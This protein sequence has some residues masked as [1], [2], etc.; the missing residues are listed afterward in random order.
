M[1][2]TKSVIIGSS[3]TKM[4]HTWKMS[5]PLKR[6]EVATLQPIK[7]WAWVITLR[8]QW[9]QNSNVLMQMLR[10]C[11]T[12]VLVISRIFR[13]PE[14]GASILLDILIL[15]FGISYLIGPSVYC[16]LQTY[17]FM[18]RV[19][20]VE[21]WVRMFHGIWNEV[22][23]WLCYSLSFLVLLSL[24]VV[25]V[26]L[27]FITPYLALFWISHDR[28]PSHRFVCNHRF[29][30]FG[31]MPAFDE[32]LMILSEYHLFAH[33]TAYFSTLLMWMVA[34]LH[35]IWMLE[36]YLE[37]PSSWLMAHASVWPP[38]GLILHMV[39][40][41]CTLMA[42]VLV[43]GMLLLH[44]LASFTLSRVWSRVA[45]FW[46][47]LRYW[48]LPWFCSLLSSPYHVLT[49]IYALSY[50]EVEHSSTVMWDVDYFPVIIDN[51]A[52]IHI[53]NT[54]ADLIE[55]SVS[56]FNDEEAIGVLTINERQYWT[57]LH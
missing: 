45:A 29:F 16:S 21:R 44:L 3:T 35:S 5:F 10:N 24:G 28:G 17:W 49:T 39:L 13:G 1:S 47:I 46:S 53:W 31:P 32:R 20:Y 26:I 43:L 41:G 4:A 57:T 50:S 36:T 9:L 14:F 2:L 30:G 40:F 42:Q 25:G 52:N 48:K 37:Y 22:Y 8:R 19:P 54:L 18:G 51:S 33:I 12:K 15:S 55:G 6:L 34:W 38:D 56:Y 7:R 27:S 11:K 23:L